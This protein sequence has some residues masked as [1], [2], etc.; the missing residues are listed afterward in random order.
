MIEV[1]TKMASLCTIECK[2]LDLKNRSFW[3]VAS[4]PKMDRVHDT[5]ALEAWDLENFKKNPVIPWTHDYTQLPV[6]MAEE[7]KVENGQ[8]IFKAKFPPVGSYPFADNVF[9]LYAA[10]ILRAFSVG[11]KALDFSRNEA[12]GLDFTKVELL[13]ISAVSIPANP[14][15]LVMMAAK[16]LRGESMDEKTEAREKTGV[17]ET[18]TDQD[19]PH[20]ENISS[21]LE[22]TIALVAELEEKIR[23]A[24]GE[25]QAFQIKTLKEELMKNVN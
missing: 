10:G 15:A 19:K 20:M 18:K 9:Q 24:E 14:D 22:K 21:K 16:S 4:T 2:A 25:W 7:I 6:A 17:Q 3:A 12:G 23:A 8:L 13:E 11:F 5:I 1:V